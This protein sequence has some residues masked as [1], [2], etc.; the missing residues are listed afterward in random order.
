MQNVINEISRQPFKT[1]SHIYPQ[2]IKSHPYL[3]GKDSRKRILTHI[4]EK[5]PHDVHVKES[6]LKPYMVK[7]FSNTLNC[8]MHDLFDNTSSGRP[9]F[10]HIF[11]GMNN[12][13]VI[14]HPLSNKSSKAINKSLLMFLQKVRP[15]KLTSDMEKSFGSTENKNLCKQYH[16]Q[17][18]FFNSKHNHSPLGIIDRFIRTLRDM[19]TP[20]VSDRLQSDDITF[21]AISPE[22]MKFLLNSYNNAVHNTIKTTPFEMYTNTEL[23]KEYIYECLERKHSQTRIND[24]SL[25]IGQHV[26]IRLGRSNGMIKKRFQ[27]SREK[28]IISGIRGNMYVVSSTD[29]SK[30]LYPRFRLVPV[31]DSQV[32]V[33]K[34]GQS[35]PE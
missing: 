13:Y 22:K 2:V 8:W 18:Q 3:N 30:R 25:K 10:W 29:G 5:L 28:Y 31:E 19:N 11:I 12:R 27:Y 26:R 6:A 7:I 21:R 34:T 1:E 14:A 23:E 16:C 15:R 24:F 32:S 20:M 9:R 35:I 33:Y 17:Y 4:D